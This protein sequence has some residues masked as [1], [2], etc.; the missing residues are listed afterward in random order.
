MAMKEG[1]RKANKFA[2]EKEITAGEFFILNG[3]LTYVTEVGETHSRNGKK[4]ARLRLIFDNGA[5]N[6]IY[7]RQLFF[8]FLCY[9]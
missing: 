4:N 8:S 9:E 6:N 2:K 7:F 3:I 1:Q 5:V